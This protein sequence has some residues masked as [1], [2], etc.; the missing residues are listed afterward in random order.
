ML[1][2]VQVNLYQRLQDFE[3]D[4]PTHEFGFTRHLMKNHGW[5]QNQTER[6]ISEY[7]KFAFLTVVANHQVVPSDRVDVVWHAHLLLTQS[8]WTEFCPK[9]LGQQLHHHPAQGGRK[10]RAEFHLL[11]AQTIASYRHFFGSPPTDIWSSPDRRF[12]AELKMQR[13]NISEHW[14]IPKKFP[15][16]PKLSNISIIAA[17]FTAISIGYVESVQALSTKIVS[18][19]PAALLPIVFVLTTILGLAL[20]YW[21][22][23]PGK[24]LQKPQLNIYE[25]AY[26]AGGGSRA[27]GLA[28]T[29][30]V[31]QGYLR[32]NVRNRTFSIEKSLPIGATK[33]EH[34]IMLK[35]RATPDL[36]S[37][38]A[39]NYDAL[40]S[41]R[42]EQEQL[43]MTGWKSLV[44]SSFVIF[45][46]TMLLGSI[47]LGIFS[48][49]FRLEI[50]GIWSIVM[51]LSIVLGHFTLCCFVPSQKTLWGHRVLADIYA[52]H[53]RYDVLQAFALN[54]ERVLSGGALDDLKQMYK[55]EAEAASGGCGCGC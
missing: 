45:I 37:L 11:Y 2:S 13:I 43:L 29:Q 25:I 51:I 40:I 14:V 4:D 55:A 33:L 16:L 42:L 23:M 52:N 21:I 10:E 19:A 15:Q 46:V 24:K 39:S 27:V 12:G 8:Y 17:I 34:R 1:N 22:Q 31:H 35:V 6:A 28:I 32:P 53:D 47:L 26:L 44:G 7:K 18:I 48:A 49:I 41:P 5:T 38:L 30:L 9:V 50:N 36:K 54:G 3:L 20:R